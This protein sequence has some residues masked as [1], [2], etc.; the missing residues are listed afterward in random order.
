MTSGR[1]NAGFD[2]IERLGRVKLLIIGVGAGAGN[3]GDKLFRAPFRQQPRPQ[4]ITPPGNG[5]HFDLRKF[6]LE[7]RQNRFIAAD[8]NN[9][10]AFF[11][12]CF[13]GFLPFLL[14]GGLHLRRQDIDR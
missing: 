5:G 4:L 7:V 9:D 10:L 3:I 1:I 2:R 6:L 12:G 13:E 14:P 11:L 8:I